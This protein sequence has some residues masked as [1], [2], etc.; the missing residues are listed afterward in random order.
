M[1]KKTW[2]DDIVGGMLL[3]AGILNLDYAQWCYWQTLNARPLNPLL[4][5]KIDYGLWINVFG[6]GFIVIG[7]LMSY[8]EHW[9]RLARWVLRQIDSKL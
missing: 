7:Y 6:Y 8:G 1:I 4:D 9:V 2:L 3:I 5:W